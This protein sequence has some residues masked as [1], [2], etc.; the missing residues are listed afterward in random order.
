LGGAFVF[1]VQVRPARSGRCRPERQC[2][3]GCD[4]QARVERFQTDPA[5]PAFLISLKAGGLGLRLTAAE[6]LFLLDP[7]WNPAVEAQAIDGA[8]PIGQTRRVIATRLV[9]C[10]TVR[11][12]CGK[13]VRCPAPERTLTSV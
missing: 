6:Y 7:W 13:A 8:H 12:I 5:C 3:S 10:N 1:P 11:G 4:R 2:G 9:A